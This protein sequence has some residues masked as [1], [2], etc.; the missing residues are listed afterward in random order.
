MKILF[1]L[2]I[3]LTVVS[4]VNAQQEIG[5]VIPAP[6]GVNP[7]GSILW[8]WVDDERQESFASQPNQRREI[9]VQAWYPAANT[10]AAQSPYAPYYQDWRN[11]KGVSQAEPMPTQGDELF[12]VI[13]M[14]PGRGMPSH[15]YTSI[16]EDLASHG[17]FVAAINSPYIGR[18]AYPNGQVIHTSDQ[19][20]IP[21]ETLIGPYEEVDKFFAEA[22]QLGADDIR[23][24]LSK[25]QALNSNDPSARFTNRLDFTRL[26]AFGHSLGGR[27]I[28]EVVATDDRFLA[29]ASMEGVPPRVARKAGLDAAVLMLLSSDL[30]DI[31]QPNIRDVIAER[32]NDVYILTLQGYGHNSVTDLPLINP[33]EATYDVNFGEGMNTI[34][35]ILNLFY[36]DHLRSTRAALLRET[37]LQRVQL[38]VF[39]NPGNG[40]M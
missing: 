23:F 22:T 6:T 4:S 39:P 13:V 40:P 31:A 33:E 25:L 19:F 9:T 16:A 12:P 35:T 21:F 7:V 36:E 34:R 17:Y 27:I 20:D 1:M 28:G 14:S 5:F 15:F 29:Y 8:H 18:V 11:V 38:E 32:R 30:P 24:A 2:L 10:N 37:N 3:S 26:G